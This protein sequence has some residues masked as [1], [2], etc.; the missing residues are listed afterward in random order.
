MRNIIK[1]LGMI[2]I[3]V[4]GACSALWAETSDLKTE[5]MPEDLFFMHIPTVITAA[6]KEQKQS[7]TTAA[8]FVITSEDIRRSGARTIPD[9]LR[10][11]PG[12]QVARMDAN[13]W[14]IT[15]RGFNGRFA[16]K[17]L[18][19]ID[20]RSVYT[21]AFS[22][23]IWEV[24]D[25]LLEDIDRIEVVR[26]PGGTLW[27]AN[28]V[29]G[30]KNIITKKATETQGSLVTTGIGTEEQG[31]G[32]ARY[33]GKIGGNL[34]YRAYA[35]YFNRDNTETAGGTEGHDDWRMGRG[36][37]RVD[38]DKGE[39]DKLTFQGDY[40]DGTAGQRVTVPDLSTASLSSRID[41]NIDL[42]GGNLL[43]RWNRTLSEDSDL[44]LQFYYDRTERS[45]FV[46]E[47]IR[48][49]FDIDFHHRFHLPLNNEILWGAKFRFTTDDIRG[50]N[51]LSVSETSRED[52]FFSAFVQDE[53][54]LIPDKLYFTL[55]SKIEHNNYTGI[56]VQPSSRILYTPNTKNTVWGAISRAVRTPSRLEHT[57]RLD[58]ESIAPGTLFPGSPATLGVIIGDNNFDSEV[59]TAF[60]IGY[61]TQP[62]NHLSFD[63]AAFY[64]LYYDLL[65]IESGT[66]LPDLTIPISVRNKMNGASY[67]VELAARWQALEWWN[68][69]GSY[70]YMDMQLH[71]EGDSNDTITEDGFEDDIPNHQF[72]IRS[73]MDLP[74][75]LE[76]D[77][78]IRYVDSVPSVNVD[79]YITLDARL[80]WNPTEKIELSIVGK[81]LLEKR[82][83][84][85]GPSS[86]INTQTTG[87]ERSVYASITWRH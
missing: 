77:S 43:F 8:T 75:N 23:V 83:K 4:M 11:V 86:I 6:K 49:T 55:G 79:S 45:E 31:F 39:N 81:N 9:L 19:M 72:S 64:N 67:G 35:K 44:S 25:T 17:L 53:I 21:P 85:Y 76:L 38:W 42:S 46:I 12:I 54:T 84:E 51:T 62:T 63:A 20:G 73:M 40:Y 22:G 60:E 78:W 66:P 82:H 47:E 27:G 30:V 57:I 70:S 3:L 69:K 58:K 7:D 28:A 52:P 26:G 74:G 16:N 68:I 13:K 18:V 10:M 33:G 37:F 61:R 80:G 71:T 56:E 41:G 5:I 65:T 34:S 15:S 14:A 32:G 24:K 59:L 50:S 1:N 2:I 36:G 48:D 29:N 87:I